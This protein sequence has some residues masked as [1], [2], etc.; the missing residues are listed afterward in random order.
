MWLVVYQKIIITN[1]HH[2]EGF[3]VSWI[4]KN[5]AYSEKILHF[6]QFYR[7]ILHSPIIQFLKNEWRSIG[8]ERKKGNAI[9]LGWSE[10][11]DR[12]G[13]QY[14]FFVSRFSACGW[15]LERDMVPPG[16]LLVPAG[17]R[18]ILLDFFNSWIRYPSSGYLV[19]STASKV[20]C[21]QKP[22]C[23]FHLFSDLH[24]HHVP[25]F[26]I[27]IHSYTPNLTKIYRFYVENW[28]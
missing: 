7:R 24:H 26:V 10:T 12:R 14:R 17:W 18:S 22:I 4:I 27:F 1:H 28:S 25:R 9:C 2:H 13:G 6:N 21:Q 8:N 15:L 16:Y 3:Q 20:C 11:V 23:L 5:S 19:S